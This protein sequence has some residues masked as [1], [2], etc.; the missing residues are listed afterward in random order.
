MESITILVRVIRIGCSIGVSDCCV[1]VS[2]YFE[3]M[4]C[5]YS[6]PALLPVHHVKNVDSIL[7]NIPDTFY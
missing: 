2:Q 6:I 5:L 7:P 1:R 3:P 4:L